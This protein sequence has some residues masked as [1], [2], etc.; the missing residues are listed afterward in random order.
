MH[1]DS[2]LAK[3][4]KGTEEIATRKYKLD[5]RLRALLI[6]VNGTSTA[7]ELQQKFAGM[8]IG[9]QLA[10][11]EREGYVK[12]GGGAAAGA[13]GAGGGDVKRARMEIARALTDALG[14]GAET[15]A[16]KIEECAT[17]G[18]LRAYLD[19][20]RDTLNAALGGKAGAFWARAESFIRA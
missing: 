2:V 12:D 18:A 7:A 14:P 16:I 5:A 11:L 10:Q 17:M 15:M 9:P 19:S 4:A 8:D 20:R 3:T 13:A 1:P 6:M